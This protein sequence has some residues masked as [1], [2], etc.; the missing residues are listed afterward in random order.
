MDVVFTWVDDTWPGYGASLAAHSGDPRDLNPNRTR[1]NL[2]LLRYGLRAIEAYLPELRRVFLFSMR[3]QVPAWLHTG[4]PDLRVVH[5]DEVIAARHLPTFNSFAIVSHLHLIP[6]LGEEFLYFEDDMLLSRGGALPAFGG[7][8]GPPVVLRSGGALKPRRWRDPSRVSPWNLALDRTVRVLE[9][10]HGAR[11][12]PQSFHVPL[13]IR[14][15]DF[16]ETMARYAP[17]IEATRQARFRSG[18]CVAPE[19]LYPL[20]ALARGTARPSAPHRPGRYGYASLEN[21]LPWTALQLACIDLARP[22]FTCL[23]DSFGARP[24][25]STEAYVRRWLATRYP[26]PSRFERASAAR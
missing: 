7:A 10:R 26:V 25:A 9:V 6:G 2:D 18:A 20:D 5:H 15:D 1:D 16:A 3:P 23:N 4:H 19:V 17:E 8:S 13:R 12:W 24:N 11:R 21:F 14:R 22:V